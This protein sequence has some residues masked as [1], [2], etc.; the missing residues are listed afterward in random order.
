MG[1]HRSAMGQLQV[2][3]VV[4]RYSEGQLIHD[5]EQQ[6]SPGWQGF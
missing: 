5:P 4:S 6:V 2:H 3:V 1:P